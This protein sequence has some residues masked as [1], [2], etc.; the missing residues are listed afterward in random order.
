MFAFLATRRRCERY[1]YGLNDR[2]TPSIKIKARRATPEGPIL[3]I[4]REPQ[5]AHNL[6][7][8]SAAVLFLFGLLWKGA[9]WEAGSQVKG[10]KVVGSQW[11]YVGAVTARRSVFTLKHLSD[12]SLREPLQNYGR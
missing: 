2:R 6:Y 7:G 3:T 1:R 8:L 5:V 12:R 10:A 4:S 11:L 9:P